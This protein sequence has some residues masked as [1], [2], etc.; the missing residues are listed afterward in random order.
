MCKKP[1]V[2]VVL[3]FFNEARF[4]REAIESVLAQTADCWELLLVDDGSHDGS[5]EIALSYAE[6]YPSRIRYLIHPGGANCGMSKSRNLGIQHANGEYVAFLDGDD[7][8]KPLKI[9]RQVEI[10]DAHPAAAMVYG[11]TE[12]WYS[13]TN[14][15]EDRDR[16]QWRQL[17][18]EPDTLVSPPR[19]VTM[20]LRKSAQTP[21]TCGILVR[22]DS[23]LH[24][25]GFE[26]GFRGM[27]EDVVFLSKICLTYPVFVER[28]RWDRYRQHPESHSRV[29]RRRGL[30][31]AR[32]PSL[33]YGRYLRWLMRFANGST[34]SDSDLLTALNHEL[35]PY[36][37]PLSYCI[38][39]AKY[40]MAVVRSRF[41]GT[42]KK[43]ENGG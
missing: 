12:H 42:L 41:A 23:I 10:L 37:T 21:G 25:G 38:A 7:V 31:R 35:R 39:A 32:G 24:I 27:F 20:F 2:S 43:L 22:R 15:P 28:G 40:H 19:L 5:S 13:W 26:P 36:R 11:A 33:T 34:V 18:V 30:Y 29:M 1:R 14:E 6:R 4:L 17:G 8:Y 3:I 16:D 9:E